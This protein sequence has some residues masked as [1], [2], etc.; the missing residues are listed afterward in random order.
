MVH[1]S[2]AIDSIPKLQANKVSRRC[3]RCQGHGIK[4]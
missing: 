1:Y 3:D 2:A 4:Q